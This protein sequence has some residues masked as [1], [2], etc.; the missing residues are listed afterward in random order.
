MEYRGMIEQEH[1]HKGYL[2]GKASMIDLLKS[3]P[4]K[5]PTY[6][7]SES[8]SIDVLTQINKSQAKEIEGLRELIENIKV[9]QTHQLEERPGSY[10]GFKTMCKSDEL[11]MDEYS[12]GYVEVEELRELLKDTTQ[13][14]KGGE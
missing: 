10:E 6:K 5:G 9:I 7:L 8:N 14:D 3:A 2:E 11:L 12:D 4:I 1:Y 13:P